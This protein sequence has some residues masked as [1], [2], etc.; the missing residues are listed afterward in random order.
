MVGGIVVP[1]LEALDD[2]VLEVWRGGGSYEPLSQCFYSCF[3]SL[4][5]L[6]VRALD[7]VLGSFIGCSTSWA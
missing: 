5:R 3:P 1:F 4:E 2:C 6:F 7:D